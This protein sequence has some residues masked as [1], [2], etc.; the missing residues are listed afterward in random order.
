MKEIIKAWNGE[1]ITLKISEDGYCFCPVC[2]EKARVKEWRPY[3]N[4]GRP[5][6]DI[7]FCGF[8][9]GFDDAGE[10]PYYTSWDEYRERWLKDEVK[11]MFGRQMS[12]VEKLKQLNN[13]GIGSSQTS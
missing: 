7:C 6:H 1:E 10:P 4:E 12:R 2:G 9:Y 3:D 11:P 8:E 13:L 5:S